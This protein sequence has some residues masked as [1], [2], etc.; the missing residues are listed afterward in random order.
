MKK[1]HR[2]IKNPKKSKHGWGMSSYHKKLREEK[3]KM[4]LEMLKR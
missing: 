4:K 3:K 1:E 2:K